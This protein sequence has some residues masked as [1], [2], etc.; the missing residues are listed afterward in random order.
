MLSSVEN[1]HLDAADKKCLQQSILMAIFVS[2]H[3]KWLDG[4]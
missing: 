1:V 3:K 4:R 2:W